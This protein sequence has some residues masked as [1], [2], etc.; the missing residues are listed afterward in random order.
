MVTVGGDLV[1]RA[2]AEASYLLLVDYTTYIPERRTGFYG[3][4]G[5][6]PILG[7]SAGAELNMVARSPF[8]HFP[9][10]AEVTHRYG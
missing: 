2:K 10:N 8:K 1:R 5:D 6:L 7:R 3:L 4:P 9:M